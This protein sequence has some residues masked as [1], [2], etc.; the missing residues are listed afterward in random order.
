MYVSNPKSLVADEGADDRSV[1]LISL[2][3]SIH[4]RPQASIG[5]IFRQSAGYV[6]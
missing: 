5:A 4:G 1:Y 6:F 2:A 3:V